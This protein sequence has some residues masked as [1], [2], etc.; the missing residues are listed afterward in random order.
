[1]IRNVIADRTTPTLPGGGTVRFVSPWGHVYSDSLAAREEG[2]CPNV[3]G[4]IRAGLAMQIKEAL[5]HLGGI[6]RADRILYPRE[7]LPGEYL[8]QLVRLLGELFTRCMIR[9][10]GP[11]P[12]ENLVRETAHPVERELE[13]GQPLLLEFC[14]ETFGLAGISGA[15]SSALKMAK[16]RMSSAIPTWSSVSGPE[17]RSGRI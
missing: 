1:M 3:T 13:C 16:P 7:V 6:Q 15:C 12:A 5:G 14:T 8:E 17:G 2:G 10:L 11:A 9:R 4:D